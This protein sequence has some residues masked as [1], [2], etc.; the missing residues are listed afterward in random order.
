MGV[1]RE[2]AEDAMQKRDVAVRL[3]RM[4]DLQY[5]DDQRRK[6]AESLGFL[7]AS[8]YENAVTH[9]DGRREWLYVAEVNGDRVGYLYLT[10]GRYSGTA[11]IVQV[12]VQRDARR[13]EYASALVDAAEA[14]A[15]ADYRTGVALRVATDIDAADFWEALGYGLHSLEAGG[16]RRGRILERRYK[17]LPCGLFVGVGCA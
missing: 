11:K 5:V 14:C 15:L 7:P 16:N 4:D 17:A 2:S 9:A 10:P 6:E 3:A 13:R 8:R 12:C 1:G